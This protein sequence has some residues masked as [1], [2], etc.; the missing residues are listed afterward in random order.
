MNAWAL[1]ADGG[2]FRS[3][4]AAHRINVCN[5]QHLQVVTVRGHGPS[6]QHEAVQ[7]WLLLES[8]LYHAWSQ[9]I[10]ADRRTTTTHDN[11]SHTWDAVRCKRLTSGWVTKREPLVHDVAVG[12]ATDGVCQ[13][14]ALCQQHGGKACVV[15]GGVQ[16]RLHQCA[17]VVVLDVPH[18]L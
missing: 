14:L 3:F 2:S 6:L 7:I 4:H 15:D 1:P 9:R 13:C 8:R 16:Q 18:P 12:K 5:Q 11:L 17:P 10:D